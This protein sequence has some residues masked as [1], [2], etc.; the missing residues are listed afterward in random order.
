MKNPTWKLANTELKAP[1]CD[2]VLLLSGLQHD[3]LSGVDDSIS[4]KTLSWES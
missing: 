3:E 1:E 4:M 2:A